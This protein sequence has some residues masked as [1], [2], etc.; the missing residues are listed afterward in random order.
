LFPTDLKRQHVQCSCR[1]VTGSLFKLSTDSR[2][3]EMADP[4]G[5]VSIVSVRITDVITDG[6]S[7]GE[8]VGK[9]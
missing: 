9:S 1:D 7:V 2:G 8:T 5:D 6:I 4:Y 3:F